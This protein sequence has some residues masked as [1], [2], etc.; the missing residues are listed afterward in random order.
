[1]GC[2]V[3]VKTSF[4]AFHRWIDAPQHVLFLRNWHRH[5]F[6]VKLIVPVRLLDR[7]VEFFTLKGSIESYL[8]YKWA[9]QY[10]EASCEQ[11]AFD[12]LEKFKASRVEVD[13][14]GENGAEVKA[15]LAKRIQSSCFVGIEAEGPLRGSVGL[16][17][18]GSVSVD[19]VK[20][21]VSLNVLERYCV[22]HV[23]YGAGN[24]HCLSREMLV[25][26]SSL[27]LPVIVEGHDLFE[28]FTDLFRGS[29]IFVS[30]SL[31]GEKDVDFRKK[32][33][34]RLIIWEGKEKDVYATSLCDPFF[35]A[36]ICVEEVG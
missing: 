26:L 28:E 5:V 21:L 13:E 3:W 15:V 23:Y 20:Q 29:S 18:P 31:D 19:R 24:D 35:D 27:C 10:F 30:V 16:F 33:V 17:V 8:Q 36:D 11:I 6:N 22:R 9:G 7:E 25:Y 12:L 32:V 1:M 34:G 2:S 14:D 4:V